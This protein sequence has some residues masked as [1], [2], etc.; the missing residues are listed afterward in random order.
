M[1]S[2][3]FKTVSD[4]TYVGVHCVQSKLGI[5]LDTGMNSVFVIFGVNIALFVFTCFASF[6]IYLT[7]KLKHS[8][9]IHVVMFLQPQ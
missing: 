4:N 1:K 3:T 8:S 2:T 5:K 6:C 7:V 9:K